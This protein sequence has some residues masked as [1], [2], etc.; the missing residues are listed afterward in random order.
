MNDA[1][2]AAG[3]PTGRVE[4]TMLYAAGL[5]QGLSLVAFPA[6]ASILTDASGYGLSK[7]EYGLLFLP[8]VVCAVA[9]SLAVPALSRRVGLQLLLVAGLAA[10]LASMT[11]LA[12]SDTVRTA[13]AAHPVLLV[14]TSLLG[15]GFGLT[16]PTLSTA[17]GG[18]RPQR[19]AVALTA[20]NVMLGLGTALSPLL[21]ALFTELAEW[22][23]L[24]LLCAVGLGVVGGAAVLR[25]IEAPPG[26]G[27]PRDGAQVPRL[28]WLFAGAVLAYGVAETMFGN[29]GTTLLRDAGVG[30]GTANYALAAFWA[31]VTGGRLLIALAPRSLPSTWVYVALPWAVAAVLALA[32]STSGGAA[33]VLVFAA[34]GLACSG[35]FPMSI[36]YGEATFP[37]LVELSAGWLVAAYQVG[38][39]LAA[40]GTGALQPDASLGTVFRVAAVVAVGMA[41]A[42]VPIARR[43]HDRSRPGAAL[44]ARA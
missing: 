31:S 24:P 17:V 28:F 11:L 9:A 40:F 3:G 42:A 39:G 7:G 1:V 8:Q 2:R 12:A 5:F 34:G 30:A 6:A 33:G 32:A 27:A 29:W 15:L 19:R 13:G 38:Y 23:L 21:V 4:I 36:G 37:D 10:N 22:W 26:S 16:L 44:P 41:V 35:F 20:L 14:A 18:L 25:P 43:Q